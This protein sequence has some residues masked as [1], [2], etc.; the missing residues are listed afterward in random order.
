[1]LT[2]PEIIEIAEISQYLAHVDIRNKNIYRGTLDEKLPEKIYCVRKN[3]EWLYDLDPTND[4]LLA[5]SKYLFAL[6]AP[7]SGEAQAIMNAGSG[8]VIVNPVTG[9]PANLGAFNLTFEMGTTSSPVVVNGV[10]VTLPPAGSNQIIIPLENVISNTVQVVRDGVI[11]PN[12]STLSQYY[13]VS[14]SPS[15]I[16][17]TLQPLGNTFENSQVWTITGWQTIS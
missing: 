4:T 14:Y 10:N 6:C 9:Q 3:V 8:G 5:T 11:L 13:T 15:Q 16:I 1:M 2:V 7:Y 12:S 17:I